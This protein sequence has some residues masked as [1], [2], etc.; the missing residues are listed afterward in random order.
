MLHRNKTSVTSLILSAAVLL[1]FVLFLFRSVIL[2]GFT[3]GVRVLLAPGEVLLPW[4]GNKFF[5]KCGHCARTHRNKTLFSV[6]V[7]K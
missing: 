4:E 3:K 2:A 7:K 1:F 5:G 6:K